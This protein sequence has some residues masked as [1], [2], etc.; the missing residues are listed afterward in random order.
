VQSV[1]TRLIVERER[2]IEKFKAEEYW[3]IEAS[4][5]KKNDDK[6]FIGK[7]HKIGEKSVGKMDINN[8]VDAKKIVAIF[9]HLKDTSAV[10]LIENR[11]PE[12]LKAE[13]KK[14]HVTT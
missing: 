6:K 5:S 13:L 2:E 1:A 12:L 8:E 4:L 10:I 7:L 14:H 11:I 3:S 9:K